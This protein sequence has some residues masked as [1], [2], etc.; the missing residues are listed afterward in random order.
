MPEYDDAV[1]SSARTARVVSRPGPLLGRPWDFHLSELA[2]DVA[3]H[4]Y[5]GYVVSSQNGNQK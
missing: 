1:P 2:G 5:D 3:S 4:G